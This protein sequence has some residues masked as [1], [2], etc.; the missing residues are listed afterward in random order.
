MVKQVRIIPNV[1]VEVGVVGDLKIRENK[2]QKVAVFHYH[3]VI[4]ILIVILAISAIHKTCNSTVDLN[5][6]G[7]LSSIVLPTILNSYLIV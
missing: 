3:C 1:V 7:R 6:L 5:K 4:S 2:I